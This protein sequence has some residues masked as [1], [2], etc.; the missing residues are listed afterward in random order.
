MSAKSRLLQ[1]DSRFYDG[2]LEVEDNNLA[3]KAMSWSEKGMQ[4][5]RDLE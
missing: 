2:S 3:S 1:L 5:S 4:F